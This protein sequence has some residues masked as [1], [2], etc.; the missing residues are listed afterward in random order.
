MDL[1]VADPIWPLP[2]SAY[3]LLIDR[4]FF[5]MVRQWERPVIKRWLKQLGN[6]ENQKE[7]PS[8]ETLND[9]IYIR[10]RK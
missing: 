6:N 4:Q 2:R 8:L 5:Q 3:R 7:C 9:S 1:M 10:C